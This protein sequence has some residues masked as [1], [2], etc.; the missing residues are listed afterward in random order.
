M[1][2]EHSLGKKHVLSKFQRMLACVCFEK[3]SDDD[4]QLGD[5]QEMV[6]EAYHGLNGCSSQLG[7]LV[8]GVDSKY[9]KLYEEITDSTTNKTK[10]VGKA[11]YSPNRGAQV[12]AIGSEMGVNNFKHATM[13]SKG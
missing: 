11:I 7:L 4:K 8:E 6:F 10:K 9:S 1:P 13:Q 5:I 3:S 2:N 12:L